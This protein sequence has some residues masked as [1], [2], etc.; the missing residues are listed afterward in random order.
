MTLDSPGSLVEE[1]RYRWHNS[2]DPRLVGAH[3]AV[4]RLTALRPGVTVSHPQDGGVTLAY[5]GLGAGLD[6]VLPFLE[7]QRGP[8]ARREH[9]RTTWARLAA[10]G[11]PE[12]DL[13]A[14]GGAAARP[15]ARPAPGPPGGGPPP[16]RRGGGGGGPPA[17]PR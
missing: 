14:V 15:R 2:A 1:W 11:V 7:Q 5:A 6:H 4:D 10:H 13:L 12:A 16:P 8:T 9:R 3:H 17:G